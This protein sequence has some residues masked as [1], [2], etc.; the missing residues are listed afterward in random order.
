MRTSRGFTLVELLV[1]LVIVSIVLVAVVTVFIGVQQS[2]ESISRSKSSIEGSRASVT[3][4]ERTVG[5]AGYGIDP[6]FGFDFAVAGGHLKDNEPVATFAGA[7]GGAVIVTDDLAYR[8]RDPNWV[9]RGGVATGS[10]SVTAP[11]GVAFRA[12]QRFLV[13]CGG[14]TDWRVVQLDAAV[15]AT[16]STAAV[17]PV[18]APFPNSAAPCLSAT[19]GAQA[20]YVMLLHERRVRITEIGGRPFLVAYRV[21]RDAT[22]AMVQPSASTEYD[23][24]AADVEDFQV[25]YAMN[26]PADMA[27]GAGAYRSVCCASTAA[28]DAAG[29]ANW[30]LLD[31][32]SEATAAF[33]PDP[34][35]LAPAVDT[36]YDDPLRFN[37][38]PANIRQVRISLMTRSQRQEAK[39]LLTH[40]S[41]QALENYARSPIK[42]DGFF[43]LPATMT[44]T[45]PN[46]QSRS[47]FTPDL[48][49][50][51]GEG[52]FNGG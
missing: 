25:S 27:A 2:Y 5:M 32:T 40:S 39:K 36:P 47:G 18:T 11:F 24:I 34:G 9:R 52:N 30:V 35:A 26:R 4:L 49:I 41:P 50:A 19:T 31:A 33:L 16:A 51:A 46:M 48:R 37:R 3:Y 10:L 42:P 1:S 38:H 20:A 8:Y 45:V 7:D 44:I 29:N 14:A 15:T 17:T 22:G 43:R 12:G 21:I 28:P 6:R 23:P 13:A